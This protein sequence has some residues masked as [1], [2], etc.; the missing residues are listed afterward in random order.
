MRA[1]LVIAAALCS[2]A[3][4]CQAAAATSRPVLR[5]VDDT[6]PVTLRGAGFHPREHVRIVLVVA[7]AQSVRKLVATIRGRFVVRIP[8]D[9]DACTGFSARA[10]GSL[11]SS[12]TFKRAPGQCPL[13]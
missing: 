2:A 12:A 9:I 13:P 1:A 8:G 6:T 5:L 7:G 11:G 4:L 3:V 10:V